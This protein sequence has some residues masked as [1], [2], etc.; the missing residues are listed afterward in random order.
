MY[1]RMLM[2]NAKVINWGPTKDGEG[3]VL[4]LDS[5]DGRIELVECPAAFLRQLSAVCTQAADHLE[6]AEVMR[7]S[8]PKKRGKAK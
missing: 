2:G 6:A 8:P 5:E 7:K 3:M 4:D 1:I